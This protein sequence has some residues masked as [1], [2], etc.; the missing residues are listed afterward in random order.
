MTAQPWPTSAIAAARAGEK[1]S[2]IRIGAATA[3]GTPKPVTPCTKLANPHA[4]S[5]ACTSRSLDSLAIARPMASMPSS[6][7]TRLNM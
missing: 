3:I 5:S 7:S 1:P 6:L 4:M 2:M